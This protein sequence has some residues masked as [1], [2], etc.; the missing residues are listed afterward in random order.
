MTT[1]KNKK[2][3]LSE[4]PINEIDRNPENPRIVF[5]QAE[6]EDLYESIRRYGVQV[7][8]AVYEENNRFVLLD[9]ERRWRCCLK[10]GKQTIPAIIRSKPTALNNLLLMF[11][12]HSLREQWDL[13]PYP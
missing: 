2:P 10:L 8:I 13:L 12:I 5:R 3:G 7:P 9:G 4:I 6:L 1:A 11:N